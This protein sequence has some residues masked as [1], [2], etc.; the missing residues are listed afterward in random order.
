[1]ST[2]TRNRFS[3]TLTAGLTAALAGLAASP[4]MAQPDGA[5][6]DYCV[7]HNFRLTTHGNLPP[8]AFLV[9]A[10]RA[11]ARTNVCK[12][13]QKDRGVTPIGLGLTSLTQTALAP[14]SASDATSEANITTLA[15]GLVVG[16]VEVHGNAAPTIAGCPPPAPPRGFGRAWATSTALVKVKGRKMDRRGNIKWRGSWKNTAPVR[17]GVGIASDPVTARLIDLTTGLTSEWTLLSIKGTAGGR[18]GHVEWD[19]TDVTNTSPT[20]K[21]ELDMTSPVT[22]Q[23]G[24]LKIVAEAGVITE[25]V[26]TGVFAGLPVPAVGSSSSFSFPLPEISMDYDLGGNPAN[27]LETE[28]DFDG[29]GETDK[30]VAG[31]EPIDLG[32]CLITDLAVGPDMTNISRVP[33]GDFTIGFNTT[34]P[35]GRIAEDFVVDGPSPVLLDAIAWPVFMPGTPQEAGLAAAFVRIWDGPPGLGLPIAGDMVT[36]RLVSTD[37]SGIYRVREDANDPTNAIKDAYIDMSWAPPLG[38]GHYWIEFAALGEVPG[39]P[40]MTPTTVWHS[41]EDNALGFNP[42]FNQW[43][44]LRDQFSQRQ[45]SVPVRFYGAA[46]QNQPCYANCDGSNIPPVLNV[47]DFICFQSRYAANDPY[48]NCDGSSVPPVLN[49][50]DFICFQSRYAAGCN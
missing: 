43:Q 20:M 7:I 38:P 1:M 3:T 40:V 35:M 39:M 25:V 18:S 5:G 50:N 11:Y 15:V 19:G 44:P 27:D 31:T 21:F 34:M 29:G 46:Q 28:F 32:T 14:G 2:S 30:A 12:D 33:E 23:Q 22:V 45:V 42:N 26:N 8:A 4:T 47:S 6:N 16:S 9:H 37:F 17:G 41:P 36:N 24:R 49:V 10:E 13:Y 48:A